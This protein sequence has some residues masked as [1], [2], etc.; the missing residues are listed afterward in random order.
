[1]NLEFLPSYSAGILPCWATLTLSAVS[2]LVLGYFGL[3]LWLWSVAILGAAV[4]CGASLPAVVVLVSMLGILNIAPL[5]R[6]LL[7]SPLVGLLKKLNI[8]PAISATERTAL[9]AGSIWVD[10]EL[11]SGAPN[12][13]WILEQDY[14]SLSDEEKAFLAGPVE[15]VCAMTDDWEISLKGDLPPEVWDFLKREKFLGMIIP[16]KYGGLEFSA[17]GNS[18]VVAKLSSRS[19]P[20]S[21]TVMVPNSLGP[22][23]LLIHYG[24]EQQKDYYLPRLAR[25]EEVPCF[26]LTEPEAGSDAGSIASSGTVFR[27]DDGKIYIKLNWEKRYITLAAVSTVLGLAAKLKDPDNLLGKGIDLGITCFLVPTNTQGVV[28]GRRHNPLGC[29]FYNCPTEGH[30]VIVSVDHII[31]GAEGAGQGWRMLMECLAAGRSISL[32]AQSTGGSKFIARVASAYAFVRKQFGVQIGK[33]EGI[34][35]PLSRIG[36]LTYLLEASRVFT[37]G[38]VIKGIKP[39]VISAI[40]K[41]NSTEMLRQN[42]NDGMD[43]LGGAGISKGPSNLLANLY[44]SVPIGI[45][46]EGAN[47]LT[48]TMIIFGQGA[49]RCH[50]YAYKEVAALEKGDIGAFDAAFWR[51]LGFIFRNLCRSILLSVTRGCFL[52]VPGSGVTSCYLRSIARSSASFALM[53]DIA[54]GVYGGNLKMR[55]KITGRFADILSWMYLALAVLRRF[56]AEGRQKEDLPFVVWALDT[57]MTKIDQGFN[58]IFQNINVPLLS[59]FFK[60]PL[61][62][63]SRLNPIGRVPCDR[64]GSSI[65]NSIAMPSAARDR[66]TDGIYLPKSEREQLAKYETAFRLAHESIAIDKKM[67]QAVK[68]GKVLKKRA[69]E[70]VDECLKAGVIT[71][72][73]ADCLQKAAVARKAVVHVDSFALADYL[74]GKSL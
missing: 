40:A 62:W 35:E 17:L 16:K 47:I 71:Q 52:L 7:T 58:G 36:G 54:M 37:C 60:G 53:T 49:I 34:E 20:L 29:S 33:F 56:E 14:P 45:T 12:F 32:P 3:P 11:F 38:A 9:E 51:H 25:G 13:K 8:L 70:L 43:I 23:E 39:A 67:R 2:I 1:M 22:A 44:T 50:P 68:S 4:G 73:E 74:S 31:G 46:V 48:R 26:A 59:W 57:A 30:D 61:T 72:A 66:L 64:V 63:W 19:T 21:I 5:R 10:A 41:Y 42:A 27:G 15:K 65:V 55:E 24:T 6:L 69:A 18:A 28:L